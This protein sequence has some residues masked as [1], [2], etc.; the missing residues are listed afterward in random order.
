MRP[1]TTRA[2]TRRR[3]AAA[4]HTTRS[5]FSSSRSES[6]ATIDVNRQPSRRVVFTA[7]L[8]FR[9]RRASVSNRP[10]PEHA[11]RETDE[12]DRQTRSNVIEER[13]RDP[14]PASALEDD[15][16]RDGAERR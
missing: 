1:A 7:L 6:N 11:D 15:E 13:D 5:P 4:T 9:L 14:A 2:S 8:P 3:A 16:I 10:Q 12:R